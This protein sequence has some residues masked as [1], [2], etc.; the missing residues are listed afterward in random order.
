MLVSKLPQDLHPNV[1][2][3]DS[4]LTYKDRNKKTLLPYSGTKV[5]F[6]YSRGLNIT[7]LSEHLPTFEL[8]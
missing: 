5:L 3:K 6:M 8:T 7:V 1:F 4:C 2:Q